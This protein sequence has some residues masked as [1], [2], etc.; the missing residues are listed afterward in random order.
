[1]RR[2]ILTIVIVFVFSLAGISA[3]F[4]P[5]NGVIS[6]GGLTINVTG[7]DISG[8]ALKVKSDGILVDNIE[9]EGQTFSRLYWENSG[10]SGELGQPEIPVIRFFLEI[11]FG[12]EVVVSIL[13]SKR[14]EFSLNELKAGERI[15]PLQPSLEKI[16][17]ARNEFLLDRAYYSG[18]SYQGYPVAEVEDYAIIRGRQI[19]I[20]T[21]KPLDYNPAQGKVALYEDLRLKFDFVGGD[22]SRTQYN[23]ERSNS[24]CFNRM[25]DEITLN[26]GVF[27]TDELPDPVGFLVI[28]ADIPGYLDAIEPLAEWKRSKGF[29]TSVVTTAETGSSTLSIQNYILDAYNNWTIPPSFILLVGDTPYIPNWTGQGTGSPAT[30]LYYAAIEGPDYFSDLGVSRFSPGSVADLQNMVNK[31]LSYE[32][33]LWVGNDDWEKHATFMAS[34]DNWN[35]SEGT[36]NYVIENYLDPAGY[37]SDRLY[38]HT[39]SATTQ[40]VTNA[41]N[42]GRSQGTYSGHGSTTGW[43]DGPPFSQGNVNALVNQVYP[44]VQSYACL[45]GMYTNGECFGETWIRHSA[46]ALAFWGASVTSYWGEDDILEKRV[47]EGIYD[48]QTPDDTVNFTWINGMTDYGKLRLYEYYG[49]SGMIQRYFEMYNVLGDGS[50]D[51]WT[52]IPQVVFVDHPAVV[53][54]GTSEV[55]VGVSGQ[56][57]WTL[58]CA[59][60]TAED[61]VYAA[62]YIDATGSVT[63]SFDPPPVMPGEMVFTATGHDVHPYIEAVP[64]IPAGGPYVVF[65]SYL[66]DDANGWNPNG[67]FDYDEEVL[68]DM[69]LENV[70]LDTS[71]G[72]DAVIRCEDPLVTIMDSTAFFGDIPAG[73]T[74]TVAGAFRIVLSP[75]V[76]DGHVLEFEIEASTTTQSW[77]SGFDIIANA[78]QVVVSRV[79]VHDEIGGNGNHAL[80]PGETADI[81]VFLTNE[82]G[83]LVDDV[84]LGITT[85]DPYITINSFIGS[86]GTLQPGDEAS[87]LINLE[88]AGACPQNHR[89]DFDCDISG[90]HSYFVE[91]QFSLMVGDILYLPTGPDAYGYSA[92]DIHDVP[93]LPVYNW[94]EIDPNLGGAGT[95]IVFT[96]D[97]QTFQFDLPFSFTYYGLDYTRFSVCSNGWIAMGETNST[98]YSNSGIPNIDGPPA[99]IAPFWED[100]SPQSVGTV[101]QYYD[102][103]EHI[104]VVEFSGVRQYYPT[105]ALETFQVILYDPEYYPTVT[106]D[107]EVKFQYKRVSDPSSCTV[108]IEN[109]SETV[110]LQYLYNDDYEIHATPIDSAIAILFTTGC[111]TP[112]LEVTLTPEATPIIIPP[113]GGSFD[114]DITIENVGASTAHFQGWIDVMLPDSSWRDLLLRSG[115]TLAPGA[116]IIR[117]MTQ[118]VP[119]LAPA[120]EYEYWAHAGIYPSNPWAEDSFPFEKTG[121]DF[122]GESKYTNWSLTGWDEVDG[123]ISPLPVEFSLSQ[124]YP[125]PFNPNTSLDFALP[126]SGKVSIK[127]YDILGREIYTLIE[128]MLDAGYYTARWDAGSNAAGIYFIRM[129]ASGFSIVRKVVLIK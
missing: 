63:L 93:I 115:L 76:P 118:N 127:V 15:F 52:D 109:H 56:P 19:A 42:E 22:M 69:T 62:G 100:L 45:T 65:E 91:D 103:S 49:H 14:V 116:S 44:F 124:N 2:T 114:Y 3:E 1:M 25:M 71:Y 75:E 28:C 104:F 106:G 21:L 17:D 122:D 6:D 32:Q 60:S 98:D 18:D 47:Y 113:S 26:A 51:M 10:V 78:P 89:A 102:A 119:Y 96:I 48:N 81:E 74:S 55:E 86:Y 120:G 66:I 126:N 41:F 46:G 54:L 39:Y 95:E 105:S 92:Y 16:P 83:C 68:L 64:L 94:I 12:A 97:D 57:H 90:E 27:G 58:V 112:D 50:V 34:N 128:G 53:Y 108:G 67:V 80:D 82:G 30:D 72:V 20:I 88:V 79:M 111:L 99:M 24:P 59:Y 29:H 7:A 121:D 35:V 8:A 123:I 40:Q 117:S 36:H 4:I 11:P 61:D 110:G 73:G 107:G 9:V 129:E 85:A 38:C 23:I 70:G 87:A 84:E 13:E 77:T 101:A 125:N 43:A 5:F 33:V 37:I 31:T